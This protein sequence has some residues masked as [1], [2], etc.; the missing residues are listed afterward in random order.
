M[1]NVL[2][3]GATGYIATPL[4]QS[5]LRSGNHHVFGL[6]R[7]QEAAKALVINEITTIIGSASDLGLIK[8]S[9]D[10]YSIDVVVNC[11]SAHSDF[12]KI[13]GAVVEAGKERAEALKAQN[14]PAVG[15]KLGYLHTSGSGV[16]GHPSERVSDRSPVGNALAKGPVGALVKGAKVIENEQLV[17]AA[18]DV[19]DVAIVRPHLIYGRTS[20]T[21]GP[22]LGP[23]YKAQL[24]S[25]ST[26]EVKSHKD[27]VLGIIHVDD[28]AA[29]MHAIIDRIEGRLGT[30]PVFEL[31]GETLPVVD[32]M[33]VAR[34]A[35]GVKAPV[36]YVG[37]QGDPFAEMLA[38]KMKT[39]ASRAKTTLGWYPLKVDFLLNMETYVKA[40]EA[41]QE[42][43]EIR[44][45]LH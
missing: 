28:V 4:A 42:G 17:L 21:L 23:L 22:F 38:G 9:I 1:P 16:Y 12:A 5:L 27:S 3:L 34:E 7:R 13:L 41:D 40:W 32:I 44:T 19:L 6:A 36:E 14:P 18:R 15:P 2:L 29:G 26:V 45:T 35:M 30:W 43:K 20:W 39:E 10:K 25:A 11:T 37:H 24:S 33:E 31:L 8:S